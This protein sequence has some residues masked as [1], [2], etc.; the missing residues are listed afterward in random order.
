MVIKHGDLVVERCCLQIW[1][2]A[3]P[4]ANLCWM[5]FVEQDQG[6]KE[7]TSFPGNGSYY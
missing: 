4:E 3:L 6:F 2:L 7:K 5:S 1:K